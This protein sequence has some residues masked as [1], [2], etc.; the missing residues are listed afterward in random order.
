MLRIQ[1]RFKRKIISQQAAQLL[2]FEGRSTIEWIPGLVK[3]YKK[4]WRSYVNHGKTMGKPWENH[5]KTMGKCWFILKL[6]ME[7]VDLSISMV[8]FHS[9]LLTFTRGCIFWGPNAPT[10]WKK[11]DSWWLVGG[12]ATYPSEKIWVRQLGWWHSQLFLEVIKFHGSSHHQPDGVSGV[13]APHYN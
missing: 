8:I 11:Q 6:A 3:V 9:F 7:I 12:W 1:P 5:G 2:F 13:G 4:L 10:W